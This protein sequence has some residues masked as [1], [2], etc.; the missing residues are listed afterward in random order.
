MPTIIT[1]LLRLAG[2]WEGEVEVDFRGGTGGA[3]SIGSPIEDPSAD[4]TVTLSSPEASDPKG[5]AIS[6]F[7]E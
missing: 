4:T 3:F 1:S 2:E 7:S 6:T 5:R